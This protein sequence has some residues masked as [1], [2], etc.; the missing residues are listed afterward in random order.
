[1]I[2]LKEK[3]KLK[4]IPFLMM[5]LFFFFACNEN[6]TDTYREAEFKE[7]LPEALALY[8]NQLPFENFSYTNL[9]TGSDSLRIMFG[10]L[11]QG[12]TKGHWI[13]MESNGPTVFT[14]VRL[15]E[16]DSLNYRTKDIDIDFN[17]DRN[18]ISVRIV[19]MDSLANRIKYS[20]LDDSS[21]S[22]NSVVQ[23]IEQP[24]R[25]DAQFPEMNLESISGEQIPANYFENKF[26]VI[27]WWA[28]WCAPCIKEIPGLNQ[29]VD[30]YRNNDNV[31]FIAI[32]D[33]PKSRINDFLKNN[34][35]KYEMT[36]AN[37]EVRT[38]FGNSYPINIIIDPPGTITY[39]SKGAGN[40]TPSEIGSSLSQQLKAYNPDE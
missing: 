4:A 16:I 17:E 15:E 34:D 25:I 9:E 26:V 27:N 20:W 19:E 32:T 36:F 22:Q 40:N 21:P 33:D 24:L 7:G 35:F 10:T 12:S 37:S 29:I 28:S 11:Q 31:I 14:T 2:A 8:K 1:M 5:L 39:I 18:R 6:E 13:A 30:K 38:V 23:N 3:L